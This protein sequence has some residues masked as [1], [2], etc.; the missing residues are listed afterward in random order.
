[1][2]NSPHPKVHETFNKGLCYF[3]I[4]NQ[5]RIEKYHI[6]VGVLYIYLHWH[7]STIG[8]MYM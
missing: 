5:M 2:F 4:L 7:L 3:F 8:C 1:M 6:L